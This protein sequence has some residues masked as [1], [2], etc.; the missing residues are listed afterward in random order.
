M[1]GEEGT[2]TPGTQ[3]PETPA[4]PAQPAPGAEGTPASKQPAG[5]EA[6]KP[7]EDGG[8][9]GGEKGGEKERSLLGGAKAKKEGEE[10]D[11]GEGGE[12]GAGG[13]PESYT[14]TVPEGMTVDQGLVDN[15]TPVLQKHKVTQEAFQE[16][17]DIYSKHL[18]TQK[19]EQTKAL[20]DELA[21]TRQEWKEEVKK[22]HGKA[23]DEVLSYCAR[24]IDQIGTPRLREFLDDTGL[25]DHPDMVKILY[26]AGKLLS[27]DPLVDPDINTP[28]G[29]TQD[30]STLYDHDN[31]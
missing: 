13:A 3:A 27:E 31:K 28:G 6:P 20:A 24:A 11:G 17:A 16:I 5:T 23:L 25:G 18:Q 30:L 8:G 21:T 26:R 7:A 29:G 12:E 9:D 15:L 4:N 22:D 14:V 2:P 1:A 19:S 10:G